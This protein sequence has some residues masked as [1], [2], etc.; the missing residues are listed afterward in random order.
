MRGNGGLVLWRDA[1]WGGPATS[2]LNP[3]IKTAALL[4]LDIHNI[5]IAAAAA[6]NTVLLDGV[7]SG[8]VL[9]FLNALLLIFGSLFKVRLARQLP[10]GGVGWAMLDSGV[11]VSKVTEVMDVTG[12]EKSTGG[13]RM[14]RSITP[15]SKNSQH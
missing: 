9:V 5:G 8:P 11:P 12:R 4:A 13:K 2:H 10:G 1:L 6:A 7:R 3:L 15:L 14:N